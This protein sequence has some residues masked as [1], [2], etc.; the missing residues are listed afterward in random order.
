MENKA[1]LKA[2]YLNEYLNQGS[3]VSATLN[4]R[5]NYAGLLDSHNIGS[6]ELDRED[7]IYLSNKYK[8]SELELKKTELNLTIENLNKLK[9][10]IEFL[11]KVV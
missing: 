9:E 5:I 3:K 6:F 7:I 4:L 2:Y 11:E 1:N 8:I 10:S